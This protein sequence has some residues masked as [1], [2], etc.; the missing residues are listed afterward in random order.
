MNNLWSLEFIDFIQKCLSEN[1]ANRPSAAILLNHPF[2]VN[3]NKGKAIIKKKINSIK[4]LIDIYREKID[5][6]E[7][8]NKF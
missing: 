8:K 6:Q 5:E 1:P 4:T 7:E 3:N 2:I